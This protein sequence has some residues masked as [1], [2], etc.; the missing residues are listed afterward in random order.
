VTCPAGSVSISKNGNAETA[1]C[2]NSP[3]PALA[4]CMK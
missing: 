3:G 2:S 4:I 1:S